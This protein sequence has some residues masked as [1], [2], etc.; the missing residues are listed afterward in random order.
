MLAEIAE[1]RAILEAIWR[2]RVAISEELPSADRE[3]AHRLRLSDAE[4]L[5]REIGPTWRICELEYQLG[6]T[7]DASMRSET[8]T[9]RTFHESIFGVAPS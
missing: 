1:T 6:V 4:L 5:E 3:Q 8:A 7:D 2:K 9:S